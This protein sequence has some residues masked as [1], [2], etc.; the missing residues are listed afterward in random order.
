[1]SKKAPAPILKKLNALYNIISHPYTFFLIF[2][3]II[4]WFIDGYFTHFDDGW[5][6]TFHLFEMSLTLIMVFIIESTQHADNRAMHEKLDEIIKT[7]PHAD[8]RKAGIEK[9]YKG[10]D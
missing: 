3:I 4:A 1:M 5:Y 6:K 9:I 10:E 8:N 7:M 2:I